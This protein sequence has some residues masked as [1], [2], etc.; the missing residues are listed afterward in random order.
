MRPSAREGK[1]IS[2]AYYNETY[3]MGGGKR[4]RSISDYCGY[5]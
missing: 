3:A 1:P 2:M 4:T 5:L